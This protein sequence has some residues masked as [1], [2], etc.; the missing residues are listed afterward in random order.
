MNRFEKRSYFSFLALYLVS[1]FILIL[2]GAFWYYTG[3]QKTLD[4]LQRYMMLHVADDISSR[5]IHAH[6]QGGSF[7]M[8]ETDAYRI[9][10]L[11]ADG[12]L[13][14]GSRFAPQPPL[15]SGFYTTPDYATL[16]TTGSNDHL[17]VRYVVVG[18]SQFAEQTDSLRRIVVK[19]T[20]AALIFVT[21]VG[22]LLSRLFLEPIR[23]KMEMIERF[24][25]DVTHEMNTPISALKMSTS[26]ALKKQQ[27]DERTLRNISASSKQL[28]DIYSALSYINFDHHD[29]AP[30][31]IDLALHIHNATEY[32][33]ELATSKSLQFVVET[34]PTPMA[35]DPYMA[36]MLINNLVSNAIKY[37]PVRST[38]TL[39]LKKGVLMVQDEGIGID[40]EK[41]SQIFERFSRATEYAGGFGLGLAIVKSICDE[42]GIKIKVSSEVGHGTT[43]MLMLPERPAAQ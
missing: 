26:R 16:V 5:V 40:P 23:R 27:Y 22:A 39:L 8:P 18:T 31:E 25:K 20:I 1:T 4:S 32:F 43:I 34:E 12:R 11:A 33:N 6:M 19:Y 9:A 35:I 29:K 37:S 36:T 17:G 24:I 30:E 7:S 15:E 41:R 13:L 2:L 21:L 10:L 3:Q 14:Y 28:Y 42:Y 38:V